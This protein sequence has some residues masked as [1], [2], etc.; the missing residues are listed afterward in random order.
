MCDDE[1]LPVL[2]RFVDRYGEPW[3]LV[4]C[5]RCRVLFERDG[6][7]CPACLREWDDP[8]EEVDAVGC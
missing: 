7:P 3:S 5:R 6:W 4:Q 8:A 2:G 1:V